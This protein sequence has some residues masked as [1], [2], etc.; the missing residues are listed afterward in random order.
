[1]FLTM[2]LRTWP[3]LDVGEQ[4]LLLLL[5]L[6]L[7]Q[8]PA[9]DD[10]VHPLRI[11]LDDPRAHRLVQEVRDVVRAA[12]V[13]LAGRQEHVDALDVDE[14]AA[15]DLALHDALDL[16]ALLVLVRH[17][18]PRAHA[19]R[20]ALRDHRRVVVVQALVEDRE[21]IARLR[22]LL[23]ELRD[24]D[25][26]LGLAADVHDDGAGPLVDPVDLGLHD[27]AGPEVLDGLGDA[28]GELGRGETAESGLD[29]LLELAGVELELPD[30]VAG[31]GHEGTIL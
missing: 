20:A 8:L 5:A 28:V 29:P 11:D 4:A 16:V 27:G 23:A 9:A 1:M 14:Q 25:L 18:L 2:P 7:E 13:D 17:D 30:A 26:A 21:H 22:Q 3:F 19:V 12:Q 6:L 15:L 31:Q 24:R 10:D